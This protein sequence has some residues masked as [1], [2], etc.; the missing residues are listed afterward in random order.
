MFRFVFAFLIVTLIGFHS[1]SNAQVHEREGEPSVIMSSP[2]KTAGAISE[3]RANLDYF[4]SAS[5]SDNP[6]Y[7]NFSIKVAIEAESQIEVEHIWVVDLR[8]KGNLI[9]GLLA[10]EPYDLPDNL[11]LGDEVVF[12]EEDV[13]DWSFNEG[14]RAWGHFT[15]RVL[16][17]ELP[18]DQQAEYESHFHK[19]P[20][21]ATE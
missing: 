7:S 11:G 10:N 8:R 9:R 14:G 18:K 12:T 16:I 1:S 5:E 3:A 19:T 4:W 15:S 2:D 20:L 17:S 13:S 6:A 21:P